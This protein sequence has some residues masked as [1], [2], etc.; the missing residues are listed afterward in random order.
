MV[1]IFNFKIETLSG[2]SIKAMNVDQLKELADPCVKRW[3]STAQPE[4][5][6][7]AI[8]LGI[9]GVEKIRKIAKPAQLPVSAGQIG[10]AY[11]ENILRKKFMSVDNV[12]KAAKSGD[13]TLFICHHK[14]IVEIKNYTSVVPQ[15]SV[16]KFLRDLET[17]GAAGGVFISLDSPISTLTQSF[18]IRNESIGARAIPC[19][20]LVSNNEASI[21]VAVEMI[22]GILGS[23]DYV[24][25]ELYA[26]DK[27]VNSVYNISENVNE[28]ARARHNL[29]LD[30]G[31]VNN[32]ITKASINIAAAEGN[33][34]RTVDALRCELFTAQCGDQITVLAELGKLAAFAKQTPVN[35][36]RVATIM[37][38]IPS[39]SWKISAK[40]CMHKGGIGFS[41]TSKIEVII[42]RQMV[43]TAHMVELIDMYGKKIS[44]SDSLYIDLDDAT[45]DLI[46]RLADPTTPHQ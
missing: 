4:D 42:P 27:V 43:S 8:E 17:T 34:R 10:E 44:L 3:L 22:N 1:W 23:Y 30:I 37:S 33:I 39:G 45:Y 12:T 21:I 9:P 19:A 15:L 46:L 25:T 7:L 36:D 20:Y 16:E 24:N 11:V 40:K 29:Q 26:R 6:L 28:L 2:Y 13:L 32:I 38:R 41:F 35:R 14:I 5:I 31:A 18:I